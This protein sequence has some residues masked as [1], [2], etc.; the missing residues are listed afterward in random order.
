MQDEI[1]YK[2]V[3]HWSDEMSDHRYLA[4]SHHKLC[5]LIL[6]VLESIDFQIF[7]NGMFETANLPLRYCNLRTRWLIVKNWLIH[8]KKKVELAPKRTW[9]KYWV[10][11]KGTML[12]FYNCDDCNAISDDSVPKHMLGMYDVLYTN[13]D[14]NILGFL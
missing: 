2:F 7:V 13:V 5:K 1:I 9:K 6:S 8:K 12:L 11:L 10:C 3:M 14:W 4:H